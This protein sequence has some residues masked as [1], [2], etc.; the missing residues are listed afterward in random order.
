MP[1]RVPDAAQKF[2]T[3]RNWQVPTPRK[4]LWRLAIDIKM[5]VLVMPGIPIDDAHIDDCS[6]GRVRQR[7]TTVPASNANVSVF[8]L[9]VTIQRI[10][11]VLSS[12][13]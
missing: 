5:G 12:L 10:Y 9:M 7:E 3:A 1:N 2:F 6:V 13:K 11:D 4:P 8:S